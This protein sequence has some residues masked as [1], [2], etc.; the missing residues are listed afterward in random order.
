MSMYPSTTTYPADLHIANLLEVIKP[1]LQLVDECI[2][3]EIASPVRTISALGEHVLSSGGKRIRP[4]LVCL[5]A[6][7]TGLPVDRTQLIPLAAAAELM[8]MATLVHDDVV[9][10]TTTRRGRPTASALFGNGVT[11]LTGDYML[12]KAMDLLVRS[13]DLSIIRVVL[14]VAIQMSEGE[15]LQMVHAH[16]VSISEDVYFDIIRKK[17]ALFIQGCCQTGAMV[18]GAPQTLVNALAQYGYHIGM[19]FQ[20]VDDLLDYT[21]NPA[22]MG[23]PAGSDLR[24]GKFT[25][26]LIIALR[27][28]EPA[29]RQRLLQLIENPPKDGEIQ[30]VIEVISHYDGFAHARSVAVHHA[31][32]AAEALSLLPAGA[33]RDS[34]IALCDYV[35]HRQS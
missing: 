33:I 7:A 1:D 15:V 13:G 28:A 30:Q 31:R 3:A 35:V 11:V 12:A 17:T 10:N 32:Q 25:L 23:K 4:A 27:E 26:P 29:D 5:S 14:Q 9:D 20:I 18:A 34:L 19:A 21:G 6:Y 16:D 8:H 24:E 2:R 22:R